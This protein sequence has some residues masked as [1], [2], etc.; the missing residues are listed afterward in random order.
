MVQKLTLAVVLFNLFWWGCSESQDTKRHRFL[1]KGNAEL[2]QQNTEQALYYYQQALKIDSCFADALNNI[3]TIYYN[4]SDFR[5][6]FVFYS[7]A[8]ACD[9][10]FDKARFNRVNSSLAMLDATSALEDL[11]K[12]R[13]HYNDTLFVWL[14]SGIAQTQLHQNE[15]A[16]QSF[17]RAAELDSANKAVKVNQASVYFYQKKYAESRAILERIITADRNQPEALN[18]LALIEEAEG[19]FDKALAL[20]NEALRQNPDNPFI[21]NN[22]ASVYLKLGRY[23]DALND[24]NQSMVLEPRNAWVYRNKAL[25]YRALG[26]KEEEERLMKQA[27]LLDPLMEF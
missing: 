19:N 6:S 24:I 25:Y 17:S 26:K 20:V 16:L 13:V 4:K 22:R 23:E 21:L 8:L 14:N 5:L 9:S 12:L 7:K 15:E 10:L 2:E 11:E 18:S 27:K 3:G 1:L